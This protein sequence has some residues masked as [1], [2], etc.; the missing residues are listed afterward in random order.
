MPP[1]ARISDMH[2]CPM[3]N[4]GPVPHVGGPVSSGEPT[5][6][7]GY[8]PAARI[9]DTAV[10]VPAVDT[11]AAGASNVIIGNKP[12]AR[13]GDSTAH[14]GVIVVGCPT[15]IIGTSS[16]SVT[17]TAA[18]TSGTPFCAECEKAKKKLE[19]E[20]AASANRGYS[21]S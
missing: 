15:V 17:L 14:G 9:G 16:Q 11:I 6:L 2:T 19:E 5:V 18:A 3:V 20:N 10:C 1:A 4:P 21:G 7:I 8:Q 12:A 13:I